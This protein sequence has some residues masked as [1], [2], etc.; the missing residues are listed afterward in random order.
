ML[1][2]GDNRSSPDR[3]GPSE[4]MDP[5]CPCIGKDQLPL[6][7]DVGWIRHGCEGESLPTES[8]TMVDLVI[9]GNGLG[10]GESSGSEDGILLSVQSFVGK[11]GRVFLGH[12][13]S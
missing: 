4:I 6:D 10:V 9:A 2:I 1:A 7:G 3:I 12:G 11:T 5:S 8:W 13:K